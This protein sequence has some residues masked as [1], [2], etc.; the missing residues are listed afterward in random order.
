MIVSLVPFAL[1]DQLGCIFQMNMCVSYVAPEFCKYLSPFFANIFL[2]F[3]VQSVGNSQ[4]VD[5][6]GI[7]SVK[8]SVH[9]K[10]MIT[11]G[12]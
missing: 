1:F 6:F 11:S 2:L 7:L 8:E 12:N 9:L 10:V 5:F 3:S 4:I